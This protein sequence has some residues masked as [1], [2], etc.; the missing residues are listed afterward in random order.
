MPTVFEVSIG[1][2]CILITDAYKLFSIYMYYIGFIDWN[3][4]DIKAALYVH[5]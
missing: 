3:E 2:I 4:I 5:L 1:I